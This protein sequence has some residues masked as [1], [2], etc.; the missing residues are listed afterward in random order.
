V[1]D[2]WY[3]VLHNRRGP[4]SDAGATADG[5][6]KAKKKVFSA[7]KAVKENARERVGQPPP[8]RVLP[9]PKQKRREK[10]KHKE[11]LDALINRTGEEG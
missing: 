9:D 6:S 2:H 8:E 10:E 4:R 1:P 3:K 11:T 7:V 5:M